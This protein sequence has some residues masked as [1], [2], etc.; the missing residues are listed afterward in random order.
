MAND[1]PHEVLTSG[2][3]TTDPISIPLADIFA[4]L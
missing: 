4:A 1:G 3:L 2:H